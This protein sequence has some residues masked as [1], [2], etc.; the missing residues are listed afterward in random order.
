M[1][2]NRFSVVVC[3]GILI[4]SSDFPTNSRLFAKNK[5]LIWKDDQI[6][7]S[8]GAGSKILMDFVLC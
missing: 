3:D 1:S 7:I 2:I 5:T 6:D 4:S 8:F